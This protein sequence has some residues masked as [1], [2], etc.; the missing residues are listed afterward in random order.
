[1]SDFSC[2]VQI[3]NNSAQELTVGF[4][5]RSGSWQGDLPNTIPA[6][7]TIDYLRL[8]DPS[9]PYGSDGIVAFGVGG[10]GGA[11]ALTMYVADPYSGDNSVEF[12]P[13]DFP[14]TLRLSFEGATGNPSGFEPGSLPTSGHP[15]YVNVTFADAAG[16]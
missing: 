12:Q 9:G 13:G 16:G 4:E 11:P 5:A 2:Y 15:V 8:E 7:T 14:A 6:H 10:G 1:M 3:A